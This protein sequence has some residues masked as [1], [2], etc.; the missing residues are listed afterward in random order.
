MAI[1]FCKLTL[2]QIQRAIPIKERIEALQKEL[3]Q[4]LA[5]S[6]PVEVSTPAPAPAP[7]KPRRKR[8]KYSAA[9]LAKFSAA[10]KARW[11]KARAAG[12]NKL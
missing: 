4:L 8:K 6:T 10:A 2:A 11:K 9:V 7:A 12:R 5:Q 3:D 1:D